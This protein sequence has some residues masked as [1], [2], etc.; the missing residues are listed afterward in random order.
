MISK[1][2]LRIYINP[3]Q[4]IHDIFCQQQQAT[5]IFKCSTLYIAI[6]RHI[7][8]TTIHSHRLIYIKQ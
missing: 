5:L 6:N 2:H 8:I 1:S 3:W 7:Q 4:N